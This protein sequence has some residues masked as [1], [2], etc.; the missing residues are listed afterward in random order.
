M[1]VALKLELGLE[2]SKGNWE[3]SE[4]TISG[5]PKSKMTVK[6]FESAYDFEEFVEEKIDC[7]GI[8]F[9]SEFCQF[10]AYAKTKERAVRFAKDIDKYFAK[11][12]KML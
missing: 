6:E 12:R 4:W 10:F 5:N 9:D 3:G 11:V 7:T 1:E 2:V 8:D